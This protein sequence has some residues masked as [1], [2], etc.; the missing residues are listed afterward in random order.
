M[1]R[2]SLLLLLL[3]TLLEAARAQQFV[4]SYPA[5]A[6]GGP[7]SGN[8]ILYLSRRNVEPKNQPGWPCYRLAVRNVRPGQA[9]T[10]SDSALSYPTLLSRL[11]RGEY[12]VQAV[13]DLNRGGRSIGQSVGN[14]YS[15]ARRV[16]LGAATDTFRLVCSQTVAAPEFVESIFCKEFKAPSALL[17]RFSGRAESLD[18]AVILPA[19]YHRHP[20]RRYPVLFTV[21]GFGGDYHHYSRAMSTDT[22]PATPID[23]LACIRVYLDGATA[24][25]HSVYA[26]SANNGPVGDAFATEFLPLLDQRYRTNGARLLRGHSSGG[27]AVVY[28]LTHYP[29][30]FA[31]GNA[32]ASDPVD[33]HR[34]ELTNLYTATKRVEMRDSVTYGELLPVASAYDRPNIVHRLEDIIYRGEQEVSFDA[35]F[36]PRGRNGLPQPLF[37]STTNVLDRRVFVHWRRYDLTQYVRQNWSRLRPYLNGK[38]RISAGNEDSYYLNFSA[39]LMEQ[40]MKKLGADMPFAYYP[41]NHFSVMTPEYKRAEIMWLKATYLN[42][43]ARNPAKK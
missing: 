13:W 12:Y 14:P 17:T 37:N 8:V 26:N 39:M 20:R 6:Y 11:E 27:Y 1:K 10:F 40:E 24:L 5:G 31:G 38:L 2:I 16:T 3:L 36:S 33:F 18:A 21:G 30:L 19:D 28:L 43:L 29:R 25:G 34:F 32:S 42:W 23:T 41:G 15:P 22:L 7:F 35:V 9:I 4:V